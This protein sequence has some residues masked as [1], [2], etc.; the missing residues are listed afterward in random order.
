MFTINTVETKL[1]IHLCSL[2]YI[3]T[4]ASLKKNIL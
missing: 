1:F 2:K 3:G 4:I